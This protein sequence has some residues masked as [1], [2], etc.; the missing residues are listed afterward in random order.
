MNKHTKGLV[1]GL[2]FGVLLLMVAIIGVEILA[3]VVY[4]PDSSA[5]ACMEQ[6]GTVIVRDTEK[7]IAF[8]PENTNTGV[9]LYPNV[10]V[11]SKAYAPLMRELAQRGILAVVAKMPMNFAPLNIDAADAI[12]ECYPSVTHWYVAGHS[13][14][15]KSAAKYLSEYPD[16]FDGLIL[17]SAYTDRKL[18]D[19][20]FRCLSVYGTNDGILDMDGFTKCLP[21]LPADC[22]VLKIEGGN[23]SNF[24]FYG[25]QWGDNRADITA[26]DQIEITADGILAFVNG[27][28]DISEETLK[29][30]QDADETT[31][32]E[33]TL[34]ETAIPETTA[35]E[36][37]VPETALPENTA[38][39]TTLPE[40]TAAQAPSETAA[41]A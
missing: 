38:A 14:G 31:V 27:E 32:P 33:T 8:V 37:T 34:P 7:Y 39:E 23:H 41:A 36:T 28:T 15:G 29:A 3:S 1:L 9:V 22:S 20:G 6:S 21:N 2:F 18:T 26:D 25:G 11:E 12:C 13:V 17:I 40:T 10:F 5:V 4:E 35:P 16:R 30:K 19:L 24:G